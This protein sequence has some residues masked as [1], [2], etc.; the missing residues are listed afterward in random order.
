[1]VVGA[2]GKN[3]WE[4]KAKLKAIQVY[5]DYNT[6]GMIMI[7]IPLIYS[8]QVPTFMEADMILNG[9]HQQTIILFHA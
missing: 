4:R 8:I 2:L 1:M 6:G 9:F 7:T 5:T 3:G